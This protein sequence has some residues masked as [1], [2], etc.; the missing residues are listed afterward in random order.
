MIQLRPA[1]AADALSSARPVRYFTSGD[2]MPEPRAVEQLRR[3]AE[4]PGLDQH[5]AVLPDVHY[6]SRNPTPTGTV[7]VSRDVLLPRA[8]DDGHNCGM[9]MIGVGLPASELGPGVLDELFRKLIEAIPITAHESPLLSEDQCERLLT[10][11]PSVLCGAIGMPAAELDRI[12]NRGT[13]TPALDPDEILTV[14][15]P[16]AI[17]KGN[18][19]LGTIGG[20]NHFLELQEIVEILD[21]PAA[22]LLGLVPG[23]TVFMLHTDSRRLG[24][25]VLRPLREEAAAVAGATAGDDL[26]TV[27]ADTELGRRLVA[28]MAA[29]THAGYANR[30]AVTHLVRRTVRSVIGDAALELPLIYDCGHES[31]QKERHNG[32][33]LWVHRHGASRALPA[34]SVAHDPVLGRIGQP[35]P[36]PGSMG[37]DSFIGVAQAGTAD[38]FHSVAHGAGRIVEK[39][40]AA[41][42]YDAAQVE[43]EMERE[44][45]RLYRYGTDEIAGQAP[46][47]FKSAA[48]VVD[49][50]SALNLVR[51]VVRLRP[52]AVL[53]G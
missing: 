32:R 8:V 52:I 23:E 44:G 43:R 42:Q 38:T 50:M 46:A 47:S 48:R 19:W 25:Q 28:G 31:I 10:H 2:L 51:P 6:K 36:I 18:G 40:V 5:I 16:K 11:G 17:R 35:V 12:E 9:R 41:G 34:S 49:V 37:A 21:P 7:I 15:R 30:S 14:V 27:S 1:G 3:L 20:G 39:A 29:A 13:M 26:W 22:G 53:K 4:V 33:W 24:K 45:I